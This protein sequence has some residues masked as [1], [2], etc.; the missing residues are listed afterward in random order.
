MDKNYETI[1][2]CIICKGTELSVLFSVGNTCL[3]GYFPLVDETDPAAT[4][5]TLK[6]CKSCG[7]LQMYEKV[8]P[9]LMFREYW[10]RSSTTNSMKAH[11]DQIAENYAIVSGNHLD[12]GCNDGFLMSSMTNRGMLSWGIDPSSAAEEAETKFPGKVSNNFFSAANFHRA[13]QSPD[14]KFDLITAISMF[15]DVPDP[16]SFLEDVR[17]LLADN[18]KAIIEVNYAKSFLEKQNIDMLGQEH[19]VYYFIKTFQIVSKQAGLHPVDAYKTEMNGGNITFILE[20]E[21]AVVSDRLAT[22]IVEEQEYLATFSAEQFQSDIDAAFQTFLDELK[23]LADTNEIKIM[24]AS[25][26]GAFIAQY[27]KLDSKIINS[28]VD[29][30]QNKIGRRIPGTDIVIEYDPDAS[31]PDIYLVMPYQFKTEII[32]RYQDYLTDGGR[33]IFYRPTMCLIRCNQ[34]GQIIEQFLN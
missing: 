33:M 34:D 2:S 17:D 13:F 1:E 18:G 31:K 21:P 5:I 11:L 12:I 19:L 4:P 22:L 29:L 30:Q 24:G 3:T 16:V 25:T 15:Y 8:N 26:R 7:N 28:A 6:S 10:Y 14:L 23:R 27:L 20:K 32:E 9:E